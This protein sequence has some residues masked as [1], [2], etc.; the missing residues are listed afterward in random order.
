M[1]LDHE[2]PELE[3]VLMSPGQKAPLVSAK[4]GVACPSGPHWIL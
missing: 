2:I 3:T 1:G 4:A